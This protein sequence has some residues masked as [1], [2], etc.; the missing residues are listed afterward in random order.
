[1][2]S[3]VP[4]DATTPV[5]AHGRVGQD[6]T[7]MAGSGGVGWYLFPKCHSACRARLGRG[8]WEWWEE[9]TLSVGG[10]SG[11]SCGSRRIEQLAT[12]RNAPDLASAFRHAHAQHVGSS[13]AGLGWVNPVSSMSEKVQSHAVGW[14]IPIVLQYISGSTTDTH[15]GLCCWS[16]RR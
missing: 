8:R 9:C 4:L 16:P 3:S 2:L 7:G 1:M 13:D 14:K 6:T 15:P 10:G 12:G 11:G 5:H